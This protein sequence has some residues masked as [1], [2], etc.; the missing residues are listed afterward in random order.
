LTTFPAA[1]Q[2]RH[3]GREPIRPTGFFGV[4][5]TTPVN[6]LATKLDAGWNLAGG[7]GITSD[8]VGINLD[9]MFT[10]FGIN[11]PTLLRAGFPSRSQRYWASTADPIFHV[12]PRGPV[13]FYITGGGGIYSQ[14]TQYRLRSGFRGPFSDLDDLVGSYTLYKPGVNGGAGF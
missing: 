8:Y 1:A 12:N 7:V 5:F 2:W 9:A 4:G 13:D 6:P 3:F 11:R 10:D 14:I